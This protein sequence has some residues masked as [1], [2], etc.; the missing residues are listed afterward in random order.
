MYIEKP[1]L[2]VS[3]RRRSRGAEMKRRRKAERKA[4]RAEELRSRREKITTESPV[5]SLGDKFRSA[6]KPV[7]GIILLVAAV[8]LTALIDFSAMTLPDVFYLTASIMW[9]GSFIVRLYLL[10]RRDNW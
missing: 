2:L 3:G 8:Y 10:S 5:T 7:D 4:E 1:W 9:A 6:V